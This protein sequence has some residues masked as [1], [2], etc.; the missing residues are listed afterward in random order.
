[1]VRL[2]YTLFSPYL[3]RFLRYVV[4][5]VAAAIQTYEK[6][7]TIFLNQKMYTLFKLYINIKEYFVAIILVGA[8]LFTSIS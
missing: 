6:M 4:V 3:L 5:V 8:R 1:M 2:A 7:N